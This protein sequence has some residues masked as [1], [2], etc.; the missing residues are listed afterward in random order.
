[1]AAARLYCIDTSSI[2]EAWERQFPPDVV[3]S[4]WPRLDELIEAG[5]LIA[6]EEVRSE[7]R[8]PSLREWAKRR[9]ALFRELTSAAQQTAVTEAVEHLRAECRRRGLRLRPTDFKADPFVVALARVEGAV[10]VTEE[11]LA[12]EA[13]AR[14]KIPNLCESFGVRSLGVLDFTRELRWTF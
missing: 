2:I 4:F 12:R 7:L 14:P 1:M 3:K 6:P 5:R 8:R 10:V 9:D 11:L 13:N